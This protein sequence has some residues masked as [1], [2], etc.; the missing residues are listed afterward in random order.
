MARFRARVPSHIAATFSA[1]QLSALQEAFGVRGT[2]RHGLRWRV[3]LH[4]PWGRYYLV[5]M[6]GRDRRAHSPVPAA[7][8]AR[9]AGKDRAR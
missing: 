4:L 6:A 2:A 9:L 3:T 5:L 7:G 1:E 8:F